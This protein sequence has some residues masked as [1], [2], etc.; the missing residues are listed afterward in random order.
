M[1]GVA[2]TRRGERRKSAGPPARA[3]KPLAAAA[4]SCY[5]AVVPWIGMR[6][7]GAKV[8]ARCDERRAIIVDSE[9]RAEV[10]YRPRSKVYRAAGRNLDPDPEA[11]LLSDDEAAPTGA[12]DPL[13]P[14]GGATDAAAKPAG[15]PRGRP[16]HGQ[17]ADGPVGSQRAVPADAIHVYT[18]GA[19]TGNPGPMG[20]G[21]VVLDQGGRRREHSEYLGIG[22]NNVAELTA[23][24]RGLQDLPRE[25]TV[26]VYSD[27][28]YALGL[29]G[30]G[31]KA[32]ANQEL[33]ER[34]RGITREFQDLRLVKVAGHA[35]VPENERCD[36]LA[37]GAV[38]RRR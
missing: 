18:D 26:V 19:C 34:L 8:W 20:I 22:T 23:I 3:G 36:E 21:V 10:L 17:V 32:K 1:R 14:R 24:L 25:R 2:L 30:K 29:L 11:A 35:G 6:L 13:P 5:N 15:A 7:R 12:A 27:S 37:R 4:G 31:W 38:Q 9:G 33:V 28:S 16:G